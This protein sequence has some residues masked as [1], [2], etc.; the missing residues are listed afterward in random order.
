M[1]IG[2]KGKSRTF[3][4]RVKLAGCYE[5]AVGKGANHDQ[6]QLDERLAEHAKKLKV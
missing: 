4:P 5:A 2:R 6:A 1:S 3:D